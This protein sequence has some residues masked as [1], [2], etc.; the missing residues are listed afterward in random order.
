MGK[1][2]TILNEPAMTVD[3]LVK[4]RWYKLT[5][6]MRNGDIVIGPIRFIKLARWQSRKSLLVLGKYPDGS[7]W[8]WLASGIIAIEETDPPQE[9]SNE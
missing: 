9:A 6:R 8:K 4:H 3:G 5:Y 1:N 7:T 2:P